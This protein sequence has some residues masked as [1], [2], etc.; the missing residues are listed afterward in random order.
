ML[1]K[2][3]KID[4]KIILPVTSSIVL[5]G[6]STVLGFLDKPVEMGLAIVAGSIGLAFSNIDKIK[7]FEGAGFKAE[8]IEKF[9][10]IVEKETEQ[11]TPEDLT[12]EEQISYLNDLSETEI[13]ILESLN[14]PKYTWRTATGISKEI[15]LTSTATSGLLSTLV[16]Y[17]LVRETKGQKRKLWTLT[18]TGRSQ[19]IISTLS[20]AKHNTYEPFS[21][22]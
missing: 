13:N 10:A 4:T 1:K 8:M 18:S 15:G 2:M 6:V 20:K 16:D 17:D 9:N 19:L 14:N 7:K 5:F 22:Q 11:D 12:T 3:K 21:S